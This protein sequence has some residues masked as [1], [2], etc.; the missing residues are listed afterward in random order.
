MTSNPNQQ[1]LALLLSDRTRKIP[2]RFLCAQAYRSLWFR[3]PQRSTNYVTLRKCSTKATNAKN[4]HWTQTGT[5]NRKK[6]SGHKELNSRRV[7]LAHGGTFGGYDWLL[8]GTECTKRATRNYQPWGLSSKQ[9][10]V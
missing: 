2:W 3:S 7:P 4:E 1:F 9:Y 10:C 5:K 8:E 6:P